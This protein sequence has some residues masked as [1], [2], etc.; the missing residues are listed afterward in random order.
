MVRALSSG[1]HRSAAEALPG[2]NKAHQQLERH[3]A[4]GG[5]PY[6]GSQDRPGGVL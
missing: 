3:S 1:C 4:E 6:H 5:R 2:Q